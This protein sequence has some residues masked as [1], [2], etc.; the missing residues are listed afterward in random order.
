MPQE[1]DAATSEVQKV[2][3]SQTLP[4]LVPYDRTLDSASSIYSTHPSHAGTRDKV[5]APPTKDSR[6]DFAESKAKNNIVQLAF[7]WII[8]N[9]EEGG[10]IR[11]WPPGRLCRTSIIL[12]G[13]KFKRVVCERPTTDVRD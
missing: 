11:F 4:T 5:L 13:C 1:R 9:L 2:T 8:H 6:Y 12:P 7:H 3:E 10:R